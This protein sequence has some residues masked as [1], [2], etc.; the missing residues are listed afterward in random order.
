MS[1][2]TV[3]LSLAGTD[4]ERRVVSEYARGMTVA[5]DP[6]EAVKLASAAGAQIAPVTVS[7]LPPDRDEERR[8]SLRDLRLLNNER[9]QAKLLEREPE[10][11]RVVVGEPAAVDELRERW[12]A[13]QRP[14][15]PTAT[16]SPGSS[17]ARPGSPSTAPSAARS[18]RRTRPRTTSSRTCCASRGFREGAAKLGAT[19]RR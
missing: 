17:P 8:F 16:G 1:A 14:D 3:M 2:P 12:E 18:A 19:P 15:R 9:A 4:V 11:C 7:W 6:G 5:N 13:P 10:R